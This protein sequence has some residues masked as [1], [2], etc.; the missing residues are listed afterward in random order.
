LSVVALVPLSRAEAQPGPVGFMGGIAAEGGGFVDRSQGLMGGA[1]VHLGVHFFGVEVYGLSQG[2]IGSVV[3]GPHNG[4]LQGVLWNS[5]M[6]GFG[7]AF[8]HLGVGPSLDFAWG[9][10]DQNDGSLC[11]SG[12]PMIGIDGRAALVFGPVAL[13][14]DIHPTFYRE[15][16]VT[17]IVGGVGWEF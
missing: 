5:A 4:A 9:C 8:F 12:A 13:S 2:F 3:A 11:Y 15:G 1:G 16:T 17:G 10:G 14:I 6:L 7:V